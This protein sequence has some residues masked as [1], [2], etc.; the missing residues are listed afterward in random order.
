[1]ADLFGLYE[2]VA[3]ATPDK[4]ERI[5]DNFIKKV[6][7][8]TGHQLAHFLSGVEVEM[9]GFNIILTFRVPLTTE[10]IETFLRDTENE[11][12]YIARELSNSR[13]GDDPHTAGD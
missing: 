1:M 8:M 6:S 2:G 5:C 7:Q 12:R 9:K 4:E 11:R 3:S 13:V 10:S